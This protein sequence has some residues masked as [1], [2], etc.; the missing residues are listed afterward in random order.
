MDYVLLTGCNGGM[1]EAIR[2][3]LLNEGYFVYGLDIIS[4]DFS[5]PNY[6]FIQTNIRDYNSIEDAADRVRKD[7]NK[8]S[9]IINTAGIYD[10]NSLIEISEEDITKIFD[11]NF[12]GVY[13]INKAF[14]PLLKENS[15]VVMVSSELAP[16]NPLP[17]TGLYGITKST[18]EKYAYS[19]R[20][21]LQ[22]LGHQ[23]IV[24]RPGA[25]ETKLLDVSTKRIEN[26]TNNTTNYKYNAK[27]FMIITE[28]VENK[29]IPPSKIANL[30]SK[31]LRK[32]KAKYVYSINRNK[33]LILLSFLPKRFQNFVIRK[34]LTSK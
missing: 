3:K 18:V 25:V 15:K 26:F 22:L 14:V 17:F 29:K 12:F 11:I 33:L 16:L 32:K 30:I 13:R 5:H 1:G 20:M 23:V 24:V 8:L 31:I 27:K 2:D 19:L 10:L 28:S 34:I 7:G 4:N 9:A 6:H 21:E